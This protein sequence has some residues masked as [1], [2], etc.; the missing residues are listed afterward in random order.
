MKKYIIFL[1]S[2]S[3]SIWAKNAITASWAHRALSFTGSGSVETTSCQSRTGEKESEAYRW[4]SRDRG[5][6]MGI[7][8]LL[9]KWAGPRPHSV[10]SAAR[11]TPWQD[12]RDNLSASTSVTNITRNR[13][14]PQ[15]GLLLWRV[16]I[17][18]EEKR[19]SL[20]LSEEKSNP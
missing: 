3:Q 20:G 16:L 2:Y 11:G 10:S 7:E 14:T 5:K 15:H 8:S 1:Y 12:L 4:M 17:K 6:D 19:R 13:N 18:R 9:I